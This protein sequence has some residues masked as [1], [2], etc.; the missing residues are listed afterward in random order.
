LVLNV[1]I[2]LLSNPCPKPS[3]NLQSTELLQR[4]LLT[5]DGTL[6]DIL[7]SAFLE[8]IDLVR[9]ETRL[10]QAST[11]VPALELE[12]GAAVM[13][14]KILLQGQRTGVNYAYAESIIATDRLEPD[15][16]YQLIHLDIP[17]GRLWL[18]NRLET[19]KQRL[20]MFRCPAGELAMHFAIDSHVELLARSYRVFNNRRPI[21]LISEYFPQ[22]YELAP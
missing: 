18:E 6:T 15:F 17:I 2:N 8:S 1:N 12:A 20:E 5:N 10:T 14:R 19:W 11:A 7:E 3:L 13:E 9:L 16:L 21:I 4:I 22:H